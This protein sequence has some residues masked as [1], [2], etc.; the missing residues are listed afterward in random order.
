M[1]VNSELSGFVVG[2]RVIPGYSLGK[3]YASGW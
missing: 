1:V 3:Y 2:V